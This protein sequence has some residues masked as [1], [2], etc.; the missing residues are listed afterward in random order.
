MK[1]TNFSKGYAVLGIGISLIPITAFVLLLAVHQYDLAVIVS[2]FIIIFPGLF[3]Y[4]YAKE[5]EYQIDEVGIHIFHHG[6]KKNMLGWDRIKTIGFQSLNAGPYG[7][8]TEYL[9]VSLVGLADTKRIIDAA[10]AYGGLSGMVALSFDPV[11]SFND[12]AIKRELDYD[13]MEKKIFILRS[14]ATMDDFHKLCRIQILS[15][16]IYDG[17]YVETYINV[18]RK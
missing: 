11:L 3:L 12:E 18:K 16:R 8:P 14:A 1:I 2:V 17:G 9:Y 5:Y 4:V 13:K 7:T 15:N 6:K 10:S